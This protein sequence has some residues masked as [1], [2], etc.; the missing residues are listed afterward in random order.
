MQ[1]EISNGT[2]ASG[3]GASKGGAA[4]QAALERAK[5]KNGGGGPAPTQAQIAATA[6]L[7]FGEAAWMMMK[8]PNHRHLFLADLEWALLPA[9]QA[10]QFKRF[11]SQGV[12]VGFIAWA[13]VSPEVD[14]RLTAGD[15]KLAPGD[16][17][18]GDIVWVVTMLAP[19]GMEKQL[20]AELV[21]GE[22]KGM[23]FK[24]HNRRPDGSREV[25]EYGRD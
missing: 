22:L 13:K 25:L 19:Q 2:G 17:T 9:L 20:L 16:W 18:S 4:V 10:H 3:A 1:S 24:V 11:H 15:G 6:S 21:A 23:N 8:S 14:A 7:I 5:Q 12:P